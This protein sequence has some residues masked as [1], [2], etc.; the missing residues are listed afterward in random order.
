MGIPPKLQIVNSKTAD[1]VTGKRF[2][3][4]SQLD[5]SRVNENVSKKRDENQVFAKNMT[6]CGGRPSFVFLEGPP[7]ANDTL[8]VH[9]VMVRTIKDIL[10]RYKVAKG[11]QVRRKA[12]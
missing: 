1:I 12:G 6:E 4:Y 10:C 3:E 8:G 9:H 11:Y 2:T 5:L 7:L